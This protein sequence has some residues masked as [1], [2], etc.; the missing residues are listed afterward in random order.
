MKEED[1]NNSI[2][3]ECMCTKCLILMALM[4]Q[5]NYFIY[6]EY[7]IPFGIL[8][9]NIHAHKQPDTSF[10]VWI[11]IYCLYVSYY[12][13][14]NS[15]ECVCKPK[16]FTVDNMAL[17]YLIFVMWANGSSV[18]NPTT[19]WNVPKVCMM[20]IRPFCIRPLRR[21]SRH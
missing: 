14:T 2:Q 17:Y 5:E 9:Q 4:T 3:R 18:K 11:Y 12:N 8:P 19:E 20:I 1:K 10:T 6:S 16:W 21:T 15:M 13:F 7:E